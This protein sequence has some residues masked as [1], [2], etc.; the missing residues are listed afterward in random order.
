M[1]YNKTYDIQ[2]VKQ[3]TSLMMLLPEL[4]NKQ[5]YAVAVEVLEHE[6]KSLPV[7]HMLSLLCRLNLKYAQE[8]K[9]LEYA[10]RKGLQSEYLSAREK[11]Y[12]LPD[13]EKLTPRKTFEQDKDS[14]Q[15]PTSETLDNLCFV[16]CASAGM[17]ELCIECIE[18]LRQTETYSDKPVV[19]VD[20]GLTDEQKQYCLA[21]LKVTKILAPKL[22]GL[23]QSLRKNLKFA[24][25]HQYPFFDEML[26]EYKYIVHVEADTWFQN[27]NGIDQLLCLCEKQ[28][29]A[30]T[31][32]FGSYG[33]Q[34]GDC[35]GLSLFAVK[36]KNIFGQHLKRVY[37]QELACRLKNKLPIDYQLLES[38]LAD[39]RPANFGEGVYTVEH[40]KGPHNV[41]L[42]NVGLPVLDKTDTKRLL[43]LPETNEVLSSVHVQGQ[44]LHARKKNENRFLYTRY[45]DATSATET[46]LGRHIYRSQHALQSGFNVPDDVY[47][48]PISVRFRVAPSL[49]NRQIKIITA[50]LSKELN[51]Y[52][53]QLERCM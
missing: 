8:V 17:F 28:G 47:A 29:F 25:N 31:Q 3:V 21:Q 2:S 36:Q 32:H 35:L 7:I 11:W 34:V 45:F 37:R 22:S 10:K 16:T 26:P 48:H 44:C 43:R 5:L 24:A 15:I 53:A 4:I 38:V 51:G 46:E 13:F 6:E 20:M 42:F 1:F 27:G 40:L 49:S 50:M 39:I 9:W 41:P 12:N 19:I 33:K 23:P 18:S 30:Y 14:D 52:V